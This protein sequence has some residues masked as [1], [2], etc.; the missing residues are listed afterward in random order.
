[1]HSCLYLQ[2]FCTGTGQ[3][4]DCSTVLALFTSR[5]GG[6]VNVITTDVGGGRRVEGSHAQGQRTLVRPSTTSMDEDTEQNTA[7]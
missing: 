3:K 4:T 6:G 7:K 5:S 2:C 1:M